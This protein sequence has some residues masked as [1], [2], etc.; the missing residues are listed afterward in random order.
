MSV[1]THFK[2][3]VEPLEPAEVEPR[4]LDRADLAAPDQRR[5]LGDRQEGQLLVRVGPAERGGSI[6]VA[7]LR[8]T[9]AAG[10]GGAGKNVRAGGTS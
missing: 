2:Q 10:R 4:Q 5:Q 3:R 7:W 1:T 9:S 6:G 8:R